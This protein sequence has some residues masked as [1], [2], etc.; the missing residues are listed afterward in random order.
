MTQAENGQDF[1]YYPHNIYI[2]VG[3]KYG[4]IGFVLFLLNFGKAFRVSI[5]QLNS[6]RSVMRSWYMAFLIILCI[7]GISE[8]LDSTMLVIWTF[9]TLVLAS[10]YIRDDDNAVLQST[11]A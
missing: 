4:L 5:T 6:G 2:A 11:H 9:F 1:G 7:N 10:P 3:A 8:G